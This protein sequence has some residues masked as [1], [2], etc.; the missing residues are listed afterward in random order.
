MLARRSLALTIG[1]TLAASGLTACSTDTDDQN[2]ADPCAAFSEYGTFTDAVVTVSSSLNGADAES[3]NES[4]E[5]FEECTGI[6]VKHTGS[7]SFES[8]LLS[9]VEDG[10]PPDIAVV[11]QLGLVQQLAEGGELQPLPNEVNGNIELGWERSWAEAG[12]FDDVP[13]AAPLRS[14]VKSLVWYSPQAFAQAG[15]EVPESWEELVE[16]TDQVVADNPDGEISPWCLGL[17]DGGATGW[18]ATDWLEE[19]LLRRSGVGA[20]DAWT[21]HTIDINDPAAVSALEEFSELVLAD[22]HVAGG[23]E[24]AV[25][26]ILEEAGQQLV[27]GQC[28]MLHASSSFENLLPEGTSIADSDQEEGLSAFYLPAE[29]GSDAKPVLAGNDYL[30]YFNESPEATAVLL[31]LTSEQWATDSVSMGGVASANREVDA[32]DLDSAVQRDATEMLQSRQSIVRF[33]ASDQMPPAVGTDLLWS[34]LTQWTL[35]ELDSQEALD[36][37]EEGWPAE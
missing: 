20:Y 28:L 30:V 31:Y 27:D 6:D 23:R 22:G 26:T 11:P 24:G 4:L 14:S 5:E 17:S 18:A 10:T 12:T 36:Q 9:S 34:V 19:I 33:D 21:S 29:Q 37:V 7:D 13:Y 8:A 2:T 1:L 16:L 25:E 3:F 35:G 32:D 15:Y